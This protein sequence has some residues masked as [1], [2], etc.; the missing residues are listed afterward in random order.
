MRPIDGATGTR[1]IDKFH[2]A[3][4]PELCSA[5]HPFMYS[6]FEHTADLG[7]HVEAGD[8]ATLFVDVAKALF[9]AIVEDIDQVLPTQ[10]IE[11]EVQ[12]SELDMLLFDWLRELLYRFDADHLLFSEFHVIVRENGLSGIAKGEPYDPTRHLLSHEVK[13]ITY[14]DLRVEELS[15]G[16]GWV[17]QVIVDI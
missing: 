7:I 2:R 4:E 3:A 15:D 11:I 13:A 12:G 10:T 9:G 14:H 1:P 8:Q 5:Y 6:Y 17:A 16:A